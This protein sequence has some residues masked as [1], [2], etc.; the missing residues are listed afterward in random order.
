VPKASLSA[1]PANE[2]DNAAVGKAG[3]KAGTFPHLAVDRAVK[4]AVDDR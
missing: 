1:K 4:E 3:D 2:V